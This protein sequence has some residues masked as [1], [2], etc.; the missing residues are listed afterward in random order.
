MPL[1]Y[2]YRR[3]SLGWDASKAAHMDESRTFVMSVGAMADEE[4]R[5]N[6]EVVGHGMSRWICSCGC[7]CFDYSKMLP[8]RGNDIWEN[9]NVKS[10]IRPT[11]SHLAI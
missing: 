7:R 6:R 4:T 8:L 10:R 5:F 9:D 11:D 2:E 1:L 3:E